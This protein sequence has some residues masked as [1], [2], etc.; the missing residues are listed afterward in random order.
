MATNALD[1][2]HANE[3]F[4]GGRWRPGDSADLTDVLDCATGEAITRLPRVSA[5]DA[6]ATVAAARQALD[7]SNW[8]TM[9]LEE[10]ITFVERFRK[11]F[12]AAGD[13]INAA[14]DVESGMPV[15]VA[16]AFGQMAAVIGDDSIAT[17]RSVTFAEVRD[18]PTG[19]VQILREPVG[20]I[21]SILTY[22]GPAPRSPSACFR[23]C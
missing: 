19:K 11:A 10:R 21:L 5:A 3:H 8:A 23:R 17:A 16:Q 7:E 22:N 14:W 12:D 6:D 15:V 18:T 9:P 20:P 1:I 4:I 2:P 13:A